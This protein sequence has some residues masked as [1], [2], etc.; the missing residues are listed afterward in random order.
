MCT[1]IR[2]E[3]VV[4]GYKMKSILLRPR[5]MFQRNTAS[6]TA[7][8]PF[9]RLKERRYRGEY[10]ATRLT[11]SNDEEYGAR[12]DVSVSASWAAARISC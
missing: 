11:V 10:W 9:K 12:R 8:S 6:P 7:A 5:R 4:T 1:E 3:K 2:L